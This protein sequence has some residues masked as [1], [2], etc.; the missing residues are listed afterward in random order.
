MEIQQMSKKNTSGQA[1]GPC[2]GSRRAKMAY[3]EVR[4]GILGVPWDPLG[5]Q[6]P[7]K[8]QKNGVRNSMKNQ[9]DS[10][11]PP[12]PDLD[13]FGVAR[14]SKMR[15]NMNPRR[16]SSAKT[17]FCQSAY[18]IGLANAGRLSRSQK[19]IKNYLKT[20]NFIIKTNMRKREPS[21]TD[22]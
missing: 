5:S 6:K 11:E 12:K 2:K 1:S 19:H 7:S 8:S 18:F 3:K 9:K 16:P 17:Y 15:G 4:L 22:L 21:E 10:K 13:R 14:S 20:S